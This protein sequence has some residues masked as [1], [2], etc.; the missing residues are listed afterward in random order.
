MTLTE[1]I[2]SVDRIQARRYS[3]LSGTA[4]EIAT[5]GIVR[6]FNA[7][8]RYGVDPDTSAIREIIDDAWEGRAV[9]EETDWVPRRPHYE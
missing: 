3:R 2:E 1:R 9:F 7:C 6:H 5:K 4:L 8:D